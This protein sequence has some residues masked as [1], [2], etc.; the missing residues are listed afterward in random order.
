MLKNVQQLSHSKSQIRETCYKSTAREEAL[1]RLDHTKV[2]RHSGSDQS[3]LA[4][5]LEG[6]PLLREIH[7]LVMS[8]SEAWRGGNSSF[9]G[10]VELIQQVGEGS[11]TKPSHQ[12]SGTEVY[13]TY[14]GL[15]TSEIPKK[16]KKIN[17]IELL[18]IEEPFMVKPVGLSMGA[19][20]LG[21]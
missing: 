9:Q 10:E 1:E 6:Q 7:I 11:K 4:K 16:S 19:Q 18:I 12:W 8:D 5:L 13:Y 15:V 20:T 2:K 3:L 14:T 21:W 17:A